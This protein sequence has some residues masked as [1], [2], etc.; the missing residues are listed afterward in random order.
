M[1]RAYLGKKINTKGY[2]TMDTKAE[3]CHV[4]TWSSSFAMIQV[5]KEMYLPIKC[6]R[7]VSQGNFISYVNRHMHFYMKGL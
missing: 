4:D 5:R 2:Q 1:A 7:Q 6:Y 3:A